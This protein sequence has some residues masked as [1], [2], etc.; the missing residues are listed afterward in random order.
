[1]PIHA[2][3]ILRQLADQLRVCSYPK[4]SRLLDLRD[5]SAPQRDTRGV[6]KYLEVVRWHRI[7]AS[8]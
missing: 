5:H 4:T 3:G 7:E 1:M 8:T 6:Q 2:L